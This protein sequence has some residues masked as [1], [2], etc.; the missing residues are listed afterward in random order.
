MRAFPFTR[1][2]ID[3]VLEED[4]WNEVIKVND[5]YVGRGTSKACMG[6]VAPEV[7]VVASFLVRLAGETEAEGV[8]LED[9]VAATQVYCVD[10]MGKNDVIVYFPNYVLLDGED[11]EHKTVANPGRTIINN[12]QGAVNGGVM[13]I[14]SVDGGVYIHGRQQ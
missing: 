10:G 2:V 8:E 5:H 11:A 12:V 1:Q 14:A 3:R 7:R 4:G 9:L 13:Q 6:F